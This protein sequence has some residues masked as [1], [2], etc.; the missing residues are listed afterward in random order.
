MEEVVVPSSGAEGIDLGTWVLDVD[1]VLT[2]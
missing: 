2:A 1:E